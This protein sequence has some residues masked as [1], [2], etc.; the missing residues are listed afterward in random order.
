MSKGRYDVR[1][2]DTWVDMVPIPTTHTVVVTDKATGKEYRGG[3]TTVEKAE[4][5][6]WEKVRNDKDK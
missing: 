1:Q 4:E 6:A 3:A 5:K 2:S